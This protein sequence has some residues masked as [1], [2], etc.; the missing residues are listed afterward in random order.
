MF[1]QLVVALLGLRIIRYHHDVPTICIICLR[2][3]MTK[4]ENGLESTR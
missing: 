3:S 1:S 4:C 2:L